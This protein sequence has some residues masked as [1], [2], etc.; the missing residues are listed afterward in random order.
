L[1]RTPGV[2][3]CPDGDDRDQGQNHG[4]RLAAAS[5]RRLPAGLFCGERVFLH[6]EF[7]LSRTKPC[8]PGETKIAQQGVETRRVAQRWERMPGRCRRDAGRA[9]RPTHRRLWKSIARSGGDR[10]ALRSTARR[11]SCAW[12]ALGISATSR[13]LTARGTCDVVAMP[14]HDAALHCRFAGG[15]LDKT[16]TCVGDDS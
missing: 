8:Q 4:Q 9:I 2:N 3:R 6:D 16:Q 10:S 15:S 12:I 11:L 13:I 14:I 7:A 5:R 1:L